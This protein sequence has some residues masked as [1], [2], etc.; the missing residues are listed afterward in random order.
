MKIRKVL[1]LLVGLISAS[2]VFAAEQKIIKVGVLVPI[3]HPAMNKIVSGFSTQLNHLYKNKVHLDIQNAMG[4]VNLQRSI[5]QKFKLANYDV[6]APIG[7]ASTNMAAALIKDKI[8]VGLAADF[9]AGKSHNCLVHSVLDEINNRTFIQF[10]RAS[11]PKSNNLILVYSN[12]DKVLPQAKDFIAQASKMHIKVVPVMV[13]NV[14]DINPNVSAIVANNNV[15]SSAIVVLKDT[16][17]VTGIS[18]LV[19]IS[20][21]H[22][23]PLIVSDEGSVQNG[24]GIGLGVKEIQIGIEGAE[25]IKELLDTTEVCEVDDRSMTALTIFVNRNDLFNISVLKLQIIA[26]QMQYSIGII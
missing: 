21:K 4:D 22:Q 17:V 18:S 26:Q 11:Y 23:I 12:T 16:V 14:T 7:V 6:I 3:Q 25:L 1:F 19:N 9:S 8:I 20:Q 10:I 15:H 13:N 2:S 24:A 5:L